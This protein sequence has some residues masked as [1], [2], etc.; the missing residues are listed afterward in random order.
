MNTTNQI[1]TPVD[2]EE[3]F[4][5]DKMNALQRH[6]TVAGHVAHFKANGLK[7]TEEKLSRLF[8]LGKPK[9]V[10]RVLNGKLF[11]RIHEDSVGV[12]TVIIREYI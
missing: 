10:I 1:G 12:M 4:D 9:I 3:T 8:E 6:M 11:S 7:T 2:Y 5:W